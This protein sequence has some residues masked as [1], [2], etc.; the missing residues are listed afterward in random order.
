MTKKL[1]PNQQKILLL[2]YG[3]I[4]LSLSTS[5]SR[6]FRILKSIKRE[7]RGIDRYALH[8]AIKKLYQSKLLEEKVAADGTVTLVLSEEGKQKALSYKLDEMQIL[9]PK[10]WDKKWRV[11]IFDVPE[12]LK[13]MRESLRGHLK[14][15]GFIYLQR[16]VFAHPFPC[17]EQIEFLIEF[18]QARPHVRQLLVE[19]I[20]NELHLKKKFGLL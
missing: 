19:K 7:W 5:P 16:S 11:V 1:G 17:T 12:Y 10:I 6:Y 2:L 14:Q 4:A 20:D 8:A 13:K 15:L 9:K 18:Y 3:G